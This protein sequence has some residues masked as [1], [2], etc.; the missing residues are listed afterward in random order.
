[1]RFLLVALVFILLPSTMI[2]PVKLISYHNDELN[3]GIMTEFIFS[4]VYQMYDILTPTKKNQ[5]F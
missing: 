3:T 4:V 2:L 5:L 1:M